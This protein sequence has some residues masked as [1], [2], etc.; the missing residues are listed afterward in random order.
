MEHHAE[1]FAYLQYPLFLV[2]SCPV[3]QSAAA[4]IATALTSVVVLG[5][6]S[7]LLLPPDQNMG[8]HLWT[9][10]TTLARPFD[11]TYDWASSEWP[12][13]FRPVSACGGF[14]FLHDKWC[15][16][17][18]RGAALALA[19]AI[20]VLHVNWSGD[21]RVQ[22]SLAV[23]RGSANHG[24]TRRTPKGNGTADCLKTPNAETPP[25][26]PSLVAESPINLS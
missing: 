5:P 12:S 14:A 23:A 19:A 9:S 2:P 21:G 16:W 10:H 17:A 18:T 13:N 1:W 8:Q 7:H 25:K 26:G 24:K 22:D 4:S 6:Q 15:P 11:L 20:V 3:K